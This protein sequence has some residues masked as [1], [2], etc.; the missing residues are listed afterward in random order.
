MFHADF[1]PGEKLVESNNWLRSVQF[2][3]LKTFLIPQHFTFSHKALCLFHTI[4][5]CAT[6]IFSNCAS[7]VKK[8]KTVDTS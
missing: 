8:N 4:L 2:W 3:G 1:N 5:V 7:Q 6:L